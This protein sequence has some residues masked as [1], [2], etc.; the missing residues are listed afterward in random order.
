MGREQNRR[1]VKNYLIN[2]EVQLKMVLINLAYV[3]VIVFVTLVVLLSPLLHDMFASHDL[4][5]QYKAAQSFLSLMKNLLPA[6]GVLFVLSFVHQLLFSHR[7]VGPLVNFGHT[8]ER[9]AEGD[10]TRKVFI[11]K[12]DCLREESERIN[13][14]MESL[15]QVMADTRS[16]HDRLI[17]VIEQSMSR[18]DEVD[19]ERKLE[20]VLD[21]LQREA[22]LVKKGLSIFKIADKEAG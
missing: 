16:S 12:G 4:E 19:S 21:L 10:F 5:V 6:V 20:D 8:F 17:A 14:M 11:R 18:I 13:A 22:L 2:K 7:I 15:S 1:H 9:I 3:L